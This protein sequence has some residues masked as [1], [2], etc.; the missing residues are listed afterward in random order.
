VSLAGARYF[1]TVCTQHRAPVLTEPD[2][3]ARIMR[4]FRAL[5]DGRDCSLHAATIMPDHVHLLLTLGPKL[6]LGQTMA[7]FKNLAR[8]LGRVPWRWLDDGFEHR[9]RQA[10]LAEDYGFYIFMN[11]YRARLIGT[12][13]VWP[14]WFCP[15]LETFRF[16]AH[17]GR[18]GQPPSEWLTLIEGTARQIVSGE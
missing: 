8:D 17:L 12:D 4:T 14:W 9:L 6:T 15:E 18:A 11:P 1:L 10:E 3:A 16:S 7:K 5:H 2:T 13:A